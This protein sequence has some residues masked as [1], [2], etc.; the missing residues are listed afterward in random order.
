MGHN[1]EQL[2]TATLDTM[3]GLVTNCNPQ[4]LPE[5][6]SPRCW[7]VDFIIGSVFTRAGLVSVYTYASSL[8]ITALQIGSGGGIGT[9][10]YSGVTPTIN[11]GFVLQGFIGTAYFLNGQTIFVIF[12]NAIAGTFTAVV[13]GPIGTYLNLTGIAVSTVGQFLGPN[14]PT[15]AVSEALSGGNAWLSPS[16]VM[17]NTGYATVVSGSTAVVPQVPLLAG[18]LPIGATVIWNNPTNILLTGSSVA[19]VTLTAGQSQNPLFVSRGVLAVPVD[20]TVTGVTVS[21]SAVSSVFGV[22][23]L[24]LQLADGAVEVALGTVV[25][26]P[27]STATATYIAGSS[28][29]QWGTTIT[30]AMVNGNHLALLV[31]AVV[32]SGTATI[33]VNS[34]VMT[35]YYQLA[36][37]SQVLQ[38]TGYVFAVPVTSGVTG[39]GVTFQAFTTAAN[40]LSVQLLQN[41]IPVGQ[42]K[43]LTLTANPTVY[44]MGLANDLWGSTWAAADINNINFGVAITAS[45]VGITSVNDLDMLVYIT[46]AQ[47]NFNYVKSYI[48]NNNQTYTLALDASGIMW[49]EDVTNAPGTLIP[50]L[51]GILPGTFAQSSTMNNREHICFS[52]L[53]IGTER[54]RTY[55]GSTFY[56]LSQVGPGAPPI[57]ASSVATTAQTLAVTAYNVPS[58]NV[59]TFTFTALSPAFTPVVNSSYTVVGSGVPGVDGTYIV[60]GTPAPSTTSFSAASSLLTGSGSITATATP[61]TLTNIVSLTQDWTWYL[62]LQPGQV[63]GSAYYPSNKPGEAQGFFGQPELWSAG[64]GSVAQGYTITAYYGHVN[65]IQNSGLTFL[66]GKQ[67]AVYVYVSGAP[68][69]ISNGTFALGLT[70]IGT[71]VEPAEA[72][73]VPYISYPVTTQGDQVYSNR[74]GP[75]PFQPTP[76]GNNGAFQIT[77][78]TV[79]TATPVPG[80]SAGAKIL[81]QGASPAAWNGSWPIVD[82]LDSG[83]YNITSSQTLANGVAQFTYNNA[84]AFGLPTVSN[85]QTILLTGLNNVAAYNTVGVVSNATAS[86]FQITGFSGALPVEP[87]PVQET[88]QGVTF[89]TKFLFDP[90][91]NTA[92][93]SGDPI[94]GDTTAAGMQ[95]QVTSSSPT[96]LTAGIRQGVVYF[97]TENEYET[98]PSAPFQFTT[99]ENTDQIICTNIPIGPPDTI[100][101]ALA[102]TE[103]GQN[104]VAGANFY[105]IEEPVTTTVNSVVTTILSTIIPDN[106]TTQ[107]TFAFTDAVL[108]NSREIDVQGDDLFNLIELGSS[109]WCVPY[110]SRM[111]Y[112]LQLNKLNNWTSGGG[113]TFDAGYLS[114]VGSGSVPSFSTVLVGGVSSNLQPLGWITA[115][116][117]DQ[118]LL[119]SPVTGQA[120]YIK[121]TYGVTTAQVGMIYQTAYQDPLLVPIIQPNTTYSVRVAVSAPSGITVGTLTIDLTDHT[122]NGF[123]TTYGSFTVPL[124]SMSTAMQVFTGTLLTNPFISGVSANL[125]LRVFLANAG[126]GAD[127]LID[128]IEVF[129]TATPY[130]MAQVYGSYPGKSESIDASSTGGIIDTT[131]EN[132]QACMGAFVMH[133][134]LYLLK[135]SSWYSTQDNP[136]SEPGG[137][138]LKEVSNKTGTIGINSYDTGEEWCITASRAGIYGFD[139]GQ[140]T[141]I[142]QE[143]WNLWEQINWEAGDTIVLRNDVTSKRLYVAIPLPTGVNPATGLP[144]N[145]Y[146]HKWLPNAPYNPTPTSPN[147]MLMLNY[148]GLADIKEMMAS[149]EVHTTMFGTLAAVDMKRKWAI[150]NIATPAMAFIMQPDGETTPLYICNGIASSKIYTLDQDN[151]SDDGVAINSLY[152]TYGFVNAAKAA[153][154]PIFGFHAKRYTVLQT[155]MTGGQLYKSTT[156]NGKIRLLPNTITPKFPY[157]VPVGIPLVDPA[158][159]DYFRTINVK[160]NRMFIEVSSNAVGSWFNLSKLLITGKA[161][162]WSTLNPTGGGNTGIV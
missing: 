15:S 123:G 136:N 135:T 97:I 6:A 162:P 32:T 30:P 113:L 95:L 11:E 145:K 157:T 73:T 91:V 5:G 144:A 100:A 8:N 39:F 104:G 57:I 25:N 139:G 149:P 22:G 24:N 74:T 3:G 114:N 75:P 67:Y 108:L 87:N 150:W 2:G 92:G 148:Q 64:P 77:M 81:I 47:V 132:A 52:N 68:I 153:T 88:G 26:K 89:G 127:V 110:A 105:V 79:I 20:A 141:K 160:G 103:A 122:S 111:F 131:T 93:T 152:T 55:N 126:A 48:Q 133:D 9:F 18:S 53:A 159:D 119:V 10:S 58:A 84:S 31:T 124:S 59:I 86:T 117:V 120:L 12:V 109:G 17:G 94:L 60:I 66:L 137:W 154:L 151:Y 106:T 142:S 129:P 44:S 29:Y 78:A 28:L 83:S 161:D 76:S 156:T 63:T 43:P 121:N 34:L 19:S 128:R 45:G 146:T 138:G 42:P 21:V 37:S 155:S 14:V 80:L 13:S 158:N 116:N 107:A 23:S 65:S 140:P 7:D 71:G 61:S 35:V 54:P 36:G 38:T 1:L 125:Q 82:A 62:P 147:V 41:G 4:D 16:S 115:N 49:R 70:G 134:L 130:L 112:G 98:T 46:P 50:V 90:G 102:F 85:G 72:G 27:L 51:S 96:A 99:P 118:T 101:R 33:S 143:I 56:P 40:T 69:S